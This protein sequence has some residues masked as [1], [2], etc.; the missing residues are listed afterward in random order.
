MRWQGHIPCIGQMKKLIKE[1]YPKTRE[2]K[3]TF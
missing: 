1:Y 3:I 2:G